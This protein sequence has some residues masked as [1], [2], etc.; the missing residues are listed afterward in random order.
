MPCCPVSSEG[1][2]S[3]VVTAEADLE[4]R[5]ELGFGKK[6]D[7]TEA[8]AKAEAAHPTGTMSALE[9]TLGARKPYNKAGGAKCLGQSGSL[10]KQS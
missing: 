7:P 10:R 3:G 4:G 8:R 1:S 5:A 9:V 6:S 2:G